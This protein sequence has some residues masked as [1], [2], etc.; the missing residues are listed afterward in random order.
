[1]FALSIYIL[2]IQLSSISIIVTRDRLRDV[3]WSWDMIWD[4][5]WAV[6]GLRHGL[7]SRNGTDK[8]SNNMRRGTHERTNKA[9]MHAHE[10]RDRAKVHSLHWWCLHGI[11]AQYDCTSNKYTRN[12]VDGMLLMAND[13]WHH[14]RALRNGTAQRHHRRDRIKKPHKGTAQWD[15]TKKL[16]KDIAQGYCTRRLHK[17]IAQ[18]YCTRRLH[19]EIARG[20]CTRRLLRGIAGSR[21]RRAPQKGTA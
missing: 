21:R 19:K 7:R 2:L 15:Y 11:Q 13:N 20:D 12:P 18:G 1:M 4:R 16:Y 10:T 6:W 3:A 5:T 17:D 14:K 8:V 9:K